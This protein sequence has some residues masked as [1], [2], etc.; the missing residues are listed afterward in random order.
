MELQPESK[1]P[2]L[3]TRREDRAAAAVPSLYA[4][5]SVLRAHPRLPKRS[6]KSNI[7]QRPPQ[8]ARARAVYPIAKARLAGQG[9]VALFEQGDLAA[10]QSADD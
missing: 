2:Q 6:P 4:K 5:W 3:F 10:G 1:I 8:Q 9:V 7:S